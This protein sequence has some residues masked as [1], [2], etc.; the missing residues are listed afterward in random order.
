MVREEGREREERERR[1]KELLELRGG[2]HGLPRLT[3]RKLFK[4]EI[5]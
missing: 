4:R 1:R 3:R 5:M 2:L